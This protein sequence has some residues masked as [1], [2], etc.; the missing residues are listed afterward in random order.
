MK[1]NIA[2]IALA[3]LLSPLASI[4]VVGAFV[5]VDAFWAVSGTADVG[6]ALDV[7]FLY[8][9]FGLLIAYPVTLIFGV[10]AY[11]VLLRREAVSYPIFAGV[12]ALAALCIA[13]FMFQYPLHLAD[14]IFG[15]FF[16]GCGA[17]VA[18]LF[19]GIAGLPPGPPN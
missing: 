15:T 5:I 1:S 4:P 12:G 6:S 11:L 2:R 17:S 16:V 19:R 7:F 8:A 10:P 3:A 13:F 14:L 18:A 9:A